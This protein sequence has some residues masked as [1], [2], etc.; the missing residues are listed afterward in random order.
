MEAL[1][2]IVVVLLALVGFS[3]YASGQAK[4]AAVISTDLSPAEAR[5]RVQ[6][7]FG[8]ILWKQVGGDGQMNFRRRMAKYEGPTLSVVVSPLGAGSTVEVWMSAWTS[9]LAIAV[10]G[11]FA[12][13]Q[14]RKVI[15]VLTDGQPVAI[16]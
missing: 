15:K 8:K 12:W 2:F 3:I 11:E 16:N 4:T 13:L 9:I 5:Q 7:A 10:G 14:K 6:S 1:T